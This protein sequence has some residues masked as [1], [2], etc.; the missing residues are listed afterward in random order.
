[1]LEL[2]IA[3]ALGVVV[4]W[5]AT[6]SYMTTRT[7]NRTALNRVDIQQDIRLATS[8][9][10]QDAQMAGSFGCAN[11]SQN[12][13]NVM[14]SSAGDGLIFGS[15]IASN[16]W[17]NIDETSSSNMGNYGAAILNSPPTITGFTAKTGTKA[18]FFQYGIGSTLLQ[19]GGTGSTLKFDAN[20]AQPELLR[21]SGIFALTS[22]KRMDVINSGV[23]LS[24]SSFSV[25]LPSGVT[26]SKSASYDPSKEHSQT[27]IQLLRFVAHLYAIGTY[28]YNGKDTTG[29]YL[30]ALEDGGVWGDP[31]L[32]SE[33]IDSLDAIFNF[34]KACKAE[35]PE[36]ELNLEKFAFDRNILVDGGDKL[37]PMSLVFNLGTKAVTTDNLDGTTT[38]KNTENY[39]MTALIRGGNVCAD[40]S[41]VTN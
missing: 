20:I 16:Q 13:A 36:T 6:E 5:A 1:M 10:S 4:I 28:N 22:C 7:L 14:L 25:D 23:S 9:I 24:S 39:Q 3:S 32:I 8:K 37:A 35:Q 40:R 11:L 41:M 2:L 12:A 18:L 26:L 29:L 38:T 34:A 19:S 27:E 33:H 15:N 17:T 31:E 30:F 21:S